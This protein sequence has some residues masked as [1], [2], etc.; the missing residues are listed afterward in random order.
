MPS[1]ALK[2]LSEFG[3]LIPVNSSGVVYDAISGHP[4]IFI[5]DAGDKLI[6]APNAPEILRNKL[7]LF[8]TNFLEMLLI[9][10]FVF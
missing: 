7:K 9:N 6:I 4:D 8:I 5:C 1:E 10:G 3:P 2:S